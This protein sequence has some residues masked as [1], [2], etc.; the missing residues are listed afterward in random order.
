MKC[1]V[2]IDLD[3]DAFAVDQAQELCRILDEA[4]AFINGG[5]S[6]KTLKDINGNTVG[7]L[8]IEE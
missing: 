5:W 1:T 8:E 2:T 7:K 4:Q 3:N 6:H